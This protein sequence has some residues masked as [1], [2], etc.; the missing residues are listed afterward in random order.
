[1]NAS[2]CLFCKIVRGEV[3][4]QKIYD[5]EDVYAFYD[6]NPQAP[7]HILIIPKKH[8][9]GV[10]ALEDEDALIA[11]KLICAA[12]KIASAKNVPDGSYRLVFNNGKLA[13]QL[14]FHIHCHLLAGR[15]MK[16]PP[17]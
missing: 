4:S 15:A 11:G 9:S 10:D 16:W 14:V 12:K 7:E 1:M 5:D 2:D 13:G 8:I 17:G 6:I 3:P